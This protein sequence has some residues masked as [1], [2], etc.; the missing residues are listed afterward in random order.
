MSTWGSPARALSSPAG[1]RGGRPGGDV[2]STPLL[3]CVCL[4][5]EEHVSPH[6]EHPSPHGEQ[7]WPHGEP[8]SHHIQDAK[9]S[10]QCVSPGFHLI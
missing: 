3:T 5:Y 8:H 7:R 6:G 4:L 1:P 9:P 10:W 2:P